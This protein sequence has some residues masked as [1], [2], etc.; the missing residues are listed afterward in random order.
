MITPIKKDVI[1][2]FSVFLLALPLCLGISTASN[3]PPVAGILSAIIGGM[4]ASF[5][6]GAKLSIKGPAAG[7]I[8][9]TVGAV[10]QLG[11]GNLQLGYERTLAVC[12]IAAIL[13]III[14]WMKKASLAEILPPSVI[15]GM[16][17]AIGVIIISKQAYVMIGVTPHVSEP[18]ELLFNFPF[19][20]SHLNP[21]LCII[22]LLSLGIAVLFP[23]LKKISFVPASIIILCLVIPLSLYLHLGIDHSYIFIGN[24]YSLGPSSLINIPHNFFKVICFPDFSGILNLTSLKYI[25]MYTLV[26]SIE[27]LLT[28]CAIDSMVVQK[29]APSNLNKDLFAV[30]IANLASA[31][32]GGLPMISEIVRSK[33]NIDYGAL[34]EKSNFFHGLF[35]LIAVVIFPSVLNLIPLSALAALLVFVGF[36]LAS[37]HEFIHAYKI[38]PDQLFI[39]VS[40]FFMTLATDLLIGVA[41]GIFLKLILHI[42]RGNSLNNLYNPL[43]TAHKFKD[44]IS[45]QVEGP[46]TFL[47]YLKLKKIIEK[48][49]KETKTIVIDL[50]LTPYLDHTV[51][52][53]FQTLA[54]EF[55][56]LKV[57]IKENQAL[58]PL[59]THSLSTRKVKTKSPPKKV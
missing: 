10:E 18:L 21:I 30:G 50:S 5:F 29:T 11:A 48:T 47:S 49:E 34:S 41:F 32:I 36:R 45:I 8:V 7:L 55:K 33:A 13:Q 2:G 56:G 6:G 58:V 52:K 39:F 12:A 26:G 42:L 20:L 24:T 53:K 17:A 38:G 28:V 3:F 40:T 19:E 51:L 37:P 59:Y 27:S 57:T 23:F 1:S 44:H 35:M 15:H 54:H 25:I 46:L 16:L 4:L 43:I 14:A 9:I 31:L 22:G